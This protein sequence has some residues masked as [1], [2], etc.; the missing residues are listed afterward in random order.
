MTLKMFNALLPYFGGK[1]KLC[2]VIFRH[3]DKYLPREKWCG[4]VFV[5]AFLG[6][7]AVSLYAKAQG[8]RVIA[9]DIAERSYI[10]GKA[11]IENAQIALTATDI[12]RLFT[13]NHD[14]NHLIEQEF[15]PE[16]FTKRHAVFLDNAF[17]NA[18][19][20]IDKYLLL[21]Y[22]FCIRPYSKFS[23]PNAFN[24]PMAEGRYDEIKRTYTKHIKD[25]LKTPLA[26]LKTEK[27]R[28]NAGIFSN[29]VKN[30]VHKGD[31]F[32]FINEVSGDVLYLDP[33]YAGTLSYESE[34]AVLD[35]ILGESKP[36]SGFSNA[37]GMDVVD[38]LLSKAGKFPLW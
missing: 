29:G 32:E 8:F 4:A 38:E 24:R 3:I 17:A 25:N 7:G 22:I 12:H 11:L 21:K 34:Y 20:A 2:P 26:I 5:D 31:V 16:V 37:D 1:R 28:V 13:P 19:R 15:V 33:P 18:K 6:S 36:K 27:E 30:E 9:N 35:R 23:S 10:A 14:N